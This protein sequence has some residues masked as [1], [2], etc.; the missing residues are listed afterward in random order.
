MGSYRDTQEV[1][2]VLNQRLQS[3]YEAG[4]PLRLDVHGKPKFHILSFNPLAY[5][6]YGTFRNR[7][8]YV[9]GSL[10][11]RAFMSQPHPDG[12]AIIIAGVEAGSQGYGFYMDGYDPSTKQ[13]M[14]GVATLLGTPINFT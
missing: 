13:T 1:L 6:T 14:E 8:P 2:G 7:A 10:A 3:R 5:E 11:L 4:E 12:T 9:A